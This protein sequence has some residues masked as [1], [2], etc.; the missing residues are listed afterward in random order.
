M[1]LAAAEL[2]DEVI[3]GRCSMF[4]RQAA[5]HHAACSLR[6]GKTGTLE[7]MLGVL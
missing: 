4:P 7:K 6:A 3:T 2:R 1:G 5:K